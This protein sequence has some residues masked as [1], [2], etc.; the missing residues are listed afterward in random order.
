MRTRTGLEPGDIGYII[1]LHGVLYAREYQLDRTVDV[2]AFEVIG[3]STDQ[4]SSECSI[5]HSVIVRV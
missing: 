1:Y 5:H 4:A 2:E 3:Y